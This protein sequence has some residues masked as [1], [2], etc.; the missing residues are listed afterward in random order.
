MKRRDF[1]SGMLSAGCLAPAL[2][3]AGES[4]GPL[5]I[6]TFD[7]DV[8]PPLGTPLCHGNVR[9]AERIVD[10][11]K[12]RGLI[13]L[14]EGAPI[15][16]AAFDWTGIGNA[17]HDFCRAELARAVGTSP[18]RVS[19]HVVHQHDA[20]GVDFSSEEILA[21][22]GLGGTLCNVDVARDA[23]RRV[24][25]AAASAVE[26]PSPVTHLGCGMA[27][28]KKVASNRR[29]LG[30][31]GKVQYVRFSKCKIKAAVD[32]P[33]GT[34]DPILRVLSFWDGEKPLA[35][36]HYYACHG[37]SFY[38]LGGVSGD[39]I[40]MARSARD[41]ALPG[42]AQIYFDGA[43]GNVACGKYNDG[44]P[45][46]RP[47]L[48]RRLEEGMA[49]AWAAT[50]KTPV[51]AADIEWRVEPVSLPIRSRTT[52]DWCRKM[53]EDPKVSAAEKR[54][55]ARDL[56]LLRR[57]QAGHKFDLTCLRIGRIYVLQMPG[58]LFVEYQLAAQKMR[59]D[60]F[61]CMAAYGDAGPTYIGTKIA[62]SQGGYEVGRSRVAPQVEDVLMPAIRKLLAVDA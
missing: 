6:A 48:A 15:V 42:V 18:D 20:P 52:E 60:D 35:A 55:V 61:V 57:L 33:E 43:G 2:A 58:E 25:G 3:R 51:T 54:H 59:P 14:G 4:A 5:E 34:I 12:A 9:P 45:E 19:V 36:V 62:Y 44:S 28:V 21:A 27:E 50:Q 47:I 40:G 26:R 39:F 31:D 16:L 7:A 29:V 30:P 11:L 8:T 37:Q 53:L 1:L 13:L 46:N 23:I 24:A 17:A 56:A 10:P 22:H 49:S 32:A 41:A 38:G